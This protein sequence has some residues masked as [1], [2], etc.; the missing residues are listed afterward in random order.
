MKTT[1]KISTLIMAIAVTGMLAFVGATTAHAQSLVAFNATA[2]QLTLTP[3][4]V[5]EGNGT[6]NIMGQVTVTIHVVQDLSGYPCDPYTAETTFVGASGSIT[7]SDTAGWVCPSATRSG[8]PATIQGVWNI[9]GGNG[10]FSGIIG[11]GA[12]QGTIAGNG[13]NVHGWSG[14]VVY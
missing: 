4:G 10:Q 9:T 3:E 13:P 7:I 5:F 6:V 12:D 8:F 2:N 11:S 14:I 1:S